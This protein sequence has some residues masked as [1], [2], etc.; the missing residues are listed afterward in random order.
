M[1]RSTRPLKL[2]WIPQFKKIHTVAQ[3]HL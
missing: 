2:A 3:L 1:P